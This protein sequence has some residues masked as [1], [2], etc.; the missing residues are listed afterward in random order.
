[1]DSQAVS[2]ALLDWALAECPDLNSGYA[3]VPAEK[4][5]ALP[6]VIVEVARVEISTGSD[7]LPWQQI[8]Q[9]L[10]EVTEANISVMADNSDPA[11]AAA[12]LRGVAEDM[13]V[14]LLKSSTLGGRVPVRSPYFEFDFTAPFVEYEDGTKGREMTLTMTV[15]DL[16]EAD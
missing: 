7:K 10:V 1:M 8:Q 2:T 16:V 14:A 6:D 15:G 11:A 12:L 13:K 9:R 4:P 5:N 3:Y